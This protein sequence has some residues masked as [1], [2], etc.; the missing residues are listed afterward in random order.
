MC[1]QTVYYPAFTLTLYGQVYSAGLSEVVLGKAIKQ[2]NLPRD[3]IV[4]L[5]KVFFGVSKDPSKGNFQ[6]N[7]A[8]GYAN[9]YGLSRKV[10]VL[11]TCMNS[12]LIGLVRTSSR[13][14]R[15]A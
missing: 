5:T 4:V 8:E 7:D 2:H 3:E 10:S 15:R 1:V 13:Q 11:A 6:P 14:C 12:V 9:Q